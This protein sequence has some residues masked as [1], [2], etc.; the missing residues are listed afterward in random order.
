MEVQTYVRVKIKY[1]KL[2]NYILT[3]RNGDG[4]LNLSGVLY[5]EHQIHNLRTVVFCSVGGRKTLSAIAGIYHYN[6]EPINL[7]HGQTLMTAL[8]KYPADDV[9][10]W[11]DEN[12]FLG[13][14]CAVDYT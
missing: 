2:Y 14:S 9:G 12:V 5:N 1:F 8:Q 4:I 3:V 11:H 6:N 13:M 7:Q 10:T